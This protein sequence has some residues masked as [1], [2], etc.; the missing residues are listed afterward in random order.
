MRVRQIT[1]S[2]VH[3]TNTFAAIEAGACRAGTGGPQCEACPLGTYSPGGTPS[4]PK[5]P[6]VPCPQGQTT[7]STGSTSVNDCKPAMPGGSSHTF[8]VSRNACRAC[9]TRCDARR[10]CCSPSKLRL[11]GAGG[12]YHIL[13]T[14]AQVSCVLFQMWEVG[15][16]AHGVCGGSR[17][18]IAVNVC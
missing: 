5:P 8:K 7:T 17:R 13:G 11:A 2:R 15:G 1:P 18:F 3:N 6:C 4:T 12:V 9:E 10:Q 14:V 16:G